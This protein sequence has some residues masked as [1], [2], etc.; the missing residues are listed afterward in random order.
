MIN[1]TD[2]PQAFGNLFNVSPE[3]GGILISV[4]V[5][6]AVLVGVSLVNNSLMAV[7][8]IGISLISLFTFLGWFP[9]W[10]TIIIALLVIV[11]FARDAIP[12]GEE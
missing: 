5:L 12:K 8:V 11:M 10:L 6:V 7:S 2:I 1:I 4:L 9:I 3:V